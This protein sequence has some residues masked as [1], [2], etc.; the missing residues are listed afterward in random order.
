V[1][2]GLDVSAHVPSYAFAAA[3][4]LASEVVLGDGGGNAVCG[5]YTGDKRQSVRLMRLLSVAIR[6]ARH[7]CCVA[8]CFRDT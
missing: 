5:S 8:V 7:S 3:T 1:S 2:A 6:L 4:P